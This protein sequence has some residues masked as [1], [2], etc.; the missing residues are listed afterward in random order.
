MKARD[1]AALAA[2]GIAGKM[3]YDKF[4]R[5]KDDEPK[6]KGTLGEAPSANDGKAGESEARLSTQDMDRASGRRDAGGDTEDVDRRAG[7]PERMG[8]DAAGSRFTDRDV[9]KARCKKRRRC[10]KSP[11]CK[12][13]HRCKKRRR[14]KTCCA[15]Q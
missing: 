13:R 4:G 1:L 10:K 14:C 15:A 9:V 2:L 7:V 12:K 8:R 11:R 3:A 6:S 5:K